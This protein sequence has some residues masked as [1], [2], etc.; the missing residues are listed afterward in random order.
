MYPAVNAG[1]AVCKTLYPAVATELSFLNWTSWKLKELKQIKGKRTFKF[2]KLDPDR[3]VQ[4][5]ISLKS[6]S[7]GSSCC[8]IAQ[9]RILTAVYK[10]FKTSKLMSWIFCTL[11]KNPSLMWQHDKPT[12]S[13]FRLNTLCTH[14]SGSNLWNL[15][16]LLSL[17]CFNSLN[18]QLLQFITYPDVVYKVTTAAILIQTRG[19]QSVFSLEK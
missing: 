9:C 4:S 5:V 10:M 17:I 6:K 15:N 19:V 14:L 13:F 3:C 1:S 2:H 18:F 11:Q 16:V 12:D 8:H 7:V